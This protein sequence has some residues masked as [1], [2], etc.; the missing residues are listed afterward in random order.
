MKHFIQFDENGEVQFVIRAEFDAVIP[1]EQKGR[2][3]EVSEAE[4][5]EIKKNPKDNLVSAGKFIKKPAK[6]VK[7]A[8]NVLLP[9]IDQMDGKGGI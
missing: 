7:T 5:L 4:A 2:F 3:I 8:E 1:D 9:T 6:A